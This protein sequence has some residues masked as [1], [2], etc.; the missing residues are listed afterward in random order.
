MREIKKAVASS[1]LY[2]TWMQILYAKRNGATVNQ[3]DQA[4]DKKKE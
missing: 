1:E 2:D 3:S 4:E